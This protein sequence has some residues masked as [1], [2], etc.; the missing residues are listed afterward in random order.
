M[1]AFSPLYD[2]LPHENPP[3]NDTPERNATRSA[4]VPA[5]TYTRG[6]LPTFPR[7]PPRVFTGDSFV[8]ALTSEPE[9]P[10]TKTPYSL[11]TPFAAS[12]TSIDGSHPAGASPPPSTSTPPSK[13]PLE[14]PLHV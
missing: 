13:E 2:Q 4:Y 14:A 12:F 8:P 6:L 9:A 3:Y 11:T 1:R 7:A 10:S 5:Q